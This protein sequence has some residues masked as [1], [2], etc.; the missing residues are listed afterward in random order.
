MHVGPEMFR[1]LETKVGL[2][3]SDRQSLSA[4][5]NVILSSILIHGAGVS[6]TA[7]RSHGRQVCEGLST[8]FR[9]R[10]KSIGS[11]AGAVLWLALF[12]LHR[13]K[14]GHISFGRILSSQ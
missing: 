10:S 11:C 12:V 1:V 3:R 14:S 6:F 13:M 4:E 9:V 2:K 8:H 7:P 5:N